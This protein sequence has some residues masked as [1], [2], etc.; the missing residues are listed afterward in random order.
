MKKLICYKI[1][2]ESAKEILQAE[3]TRHAKV[4]NDALNMDLWEK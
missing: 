2:E 4:L 3:I 1:D